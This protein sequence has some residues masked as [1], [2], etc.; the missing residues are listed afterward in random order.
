MDLWNLAKTPEEYKHS[1]GKYYIC[2]VHGE[3]HITNYLEIPD[4]DFGNE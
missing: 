3:Y 4:F 2:G 1:S